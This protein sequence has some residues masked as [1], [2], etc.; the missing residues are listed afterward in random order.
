MP[1]SVIAVLLLVLS[2]ISIALVYG[3]D[4]NQEGAAMPEKTLEQMRKC[5]DNALQ[6][7][8]RRAYSW[9][10]PRSRPPRT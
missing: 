1:F 2:S 5:V 6:D 8:V 4:P 10:S 3:L 9:P 7:V